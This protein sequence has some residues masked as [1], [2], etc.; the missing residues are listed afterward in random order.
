MKILT[1]VGARPQFIKA[2]VVSR[3]I[4]RQEESGLS[5]VLLHTGQHYDFGMSDVFFKEM[6][7]PTPLINLQVGAG[8]QGATTA[9]MLSGCESAM[10]QIKPDLVLVYGDTNSTLAGAL[11]A[12]KL[13]IPIAH[14]EAGLRSFNRRMPEEINRV[15]TDHMS[16][17]HFCT[18]QAAVNQL[19]TEGISDKVFNV[20]DVMY[21][22][23]VL[24]SP[25]AKAPAEFS[26]LETPY[27]LA[28]IHRAENTNS[29]EILKNL[30]TALAGCPIRVCLPLHPRTRK[31]A[32]ENGITPGENVKIIAPVSYLEMLALLKNA[33]FVMTDSGGL[34]KEAYFAGKKCLTLREET[35]WTELV[36]IGANKVVGTS[37]ER[38]LAQIDWARS[39]TPLQGSLY[40]DGKAAEKIVAAIQ[41][42]LAAAASLQQKVK[43]RDL[44]SL[45]PLQLE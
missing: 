16:T 24:S 12:A 41:Q 2:A 29:P 44:G 15:V 36:D 31:V 14:V 45:P 11:A 39:T 1:V 8:A 22:A 42:N 18:S 28:T 7:I 21:D 20:G 9:A 43:R 13:S 34:Q 25:D 38:I 10:Q 32:E 19:A 3:E 5:E 17:L 33:S 23:F 30:F 37:P 27:A 4:A 6:G 26:D 40:G 35:E